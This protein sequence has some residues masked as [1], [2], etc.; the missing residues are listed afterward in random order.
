MNNKGITVV[1]TSCG[2][3]DLLERT[4]AS[5]DKFNTAPIARKFIVEDGGADFMSGIRKDGWHV[6]CT[7][8]DE[9]KRV[10][11]IMAIDVAYSFVKTPYIFHLEDDWQFYAPGFIERSLQVLE[12]EPKCITVWLRHPADTN[13][14]PVKPYHNE[15]GLMKLSTNYKWKGFTFN[16]GLRRLADY[17]LLAP[18]SDHIKW[19]PKLPWLGEKKIGDLYHNLGYYAAIFKGS[20]YVRH[21]GAGRHVI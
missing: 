3:P 12:S 7:R 18:F 21:I 17:K 20:G 1:L 4:I 8:N 15:F 2:R 19:D 11:Q 10:G 16:P 5:F 13:G 9:G 14:H 6:V